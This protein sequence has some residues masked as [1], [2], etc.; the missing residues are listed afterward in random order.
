M[1]PKPLPLQIDGLHKAF[2]GRPVLKGVS[3][4]FAPG[5]LSVLIGRSGSG[6]STLLRCFNGLERPDAGHLSSHARMGMVFQQ[7]HLFPHL[8]ILD[9]LLLAPRVA[10]GRRDDGALRAECLALLAKVGLDG[11]ARHYPSQLSGGQQQRAAIAR[12][13]ACRPEVLLYDEPTSSLDPHLAEEVLQVMARLRRDGLTQ[14]LVTHELDFARRYA[15]HVVFLEDG[16]VVEQG[17]PKA[18]FGRPQD[19]RTRRFLK[20][21][22]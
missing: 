16:V 2:Q 10:Q 5:R 7:F 1:S 11:H 12:A 18:L 6:K 4:S 13:P 22:R 3:L 8:D 14:V 21:A 19:A 9:N 17:P 20:G 15:D